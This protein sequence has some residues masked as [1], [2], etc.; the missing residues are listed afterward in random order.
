[1]ARA[2]PKREEVREWFIAYRS[3]RDRALRN[4]IIEAHK[5]LAVHIAQGF[6]QRGEPFDD[7][8]QVA[9][10]GMLKAVER[11]EPE[12]NF[13]F[14]TFATA[15][16]QGELKRHFRDRTWSVHVPRR[17]KD[18]HLKLG[19]TVPLLAQKLGRSPSISELA[20]EMDVTEDDVLQAMEA[21]SAYRSASLEASKS[22]SDSSYPSLADRIGRD[23]DGFHDAEVRDV[24]NK[25]LDKLAPRDRQI[26]EMR[27][28]EELTQTEI[29]ETVG[30][31]QM[32]VSRLLSRA[33]GD[34]RSRIAEPSQE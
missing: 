4:R 23:D 28:F 25:L 20:R 5:P 34:L 3:S 16:I 9:Q 15:T 8:L 24:V 26:L 19:K 30:V 18:L 17:A 1:M 6:A 29:A 13:E 7:L 2:N 22:T 21:G 33:L 10:L 32:H 11:F 12:R 14:S 27:F 31:S